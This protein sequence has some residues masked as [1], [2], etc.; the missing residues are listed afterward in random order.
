LDYDS[1]VSFIDFLILDKFTQKYQMVLEFKKDKIAKEKMFEQLQRTKGVV[2]L[3]VT[4]KGYYGAVNQTHFFIKDNK[5]NDV[6]EFEL[7]D[8]SKIQN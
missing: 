4:Y 1:D 2:E 6:I 3:S 8:V 5:W 7:K